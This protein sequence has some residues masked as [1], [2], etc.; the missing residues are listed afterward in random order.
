MDLIVSPVVSIDIKSPSFPIVMM[1]T[2]PDFPGVIIVYSSQD[3]FRIFRK[4]GSAL[5]EQMSLKVSNVS[6]NIEDLSM[7]ILGSTHILVASNIAS[8]NFRILDRY[9]NFLVYAVSGT[10]YLMDL[11]RG[12]V[13]AKITASPS[14]G[15]I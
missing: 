8:S 11:S 3:Y 7:I 14:S 10:C 1:K 6:K 15:V 13:V 5:D 4:N 2:S 9:I 12:I